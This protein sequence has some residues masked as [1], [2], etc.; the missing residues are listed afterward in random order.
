MDIGKLRP[1][2]TMLFVPGNRPGWLE[3]ALAAGPD[4]VVLDLEDSVPVAD[5]PAARA[6]VAEA[7][8]RTAGTTAARL[9]VRVNRGA[10]LYDFEDI[11]AAVR[12]GLSALFIPKAEDATDVE[13][14]SRMTAEAEE[15]TGLA[16][17]NVHFVVALETARAVQLSF[18]I[19]SHPRVETLT[20]CA[21]RN[22]DVARALGFE[23]TPEG[24][25]TLFQRSRAVT[26]CRAAGKPYPVGGL[27][28]DVHDL[29]GLRT[30]AEFNR[31]LGFRGEIVLHPSNVPVVNEVYSLSAGDRAYYEG[32]LE[33]FAK[34]EAEGRASV[35]YAGEH[36]DIAHVA[37]AR[38]ILRA[39][40][41]G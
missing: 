17:G 37:T 13:F 10:H 14:A 30:F 1:I 12:P 4:A 16:P 8:D 29:Q 39:A 19:A 41:N 5:K 26:A 24:L 23:W 3:K 40:E 34:A 2:R 33:A 38:E 25:E 22:A 20:A 32:M 9:M 6:M 28:Q 7:I 15:R 35:M 11:L 31:R 27:W 18:D 36:I 21:A